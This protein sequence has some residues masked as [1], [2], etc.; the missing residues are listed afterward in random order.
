DVPDVLLGGDHD[1]VARWRLEQMVRRTR[2]RRP[3][4]LD[5]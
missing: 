2:E 3:D 5:E 4:L 1:A